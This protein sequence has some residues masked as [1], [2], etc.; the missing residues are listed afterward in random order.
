MGAAAGYR[1]L[2]SRR[3][4]QAIA[5]EPLP[6]SAAASPAPRRGEQPGGEDD[7]PDDSRRPRHRVSLSEALAA[8]QASGDAAAVDVPGPKEIAAAPEA[9][10]KALL[11]EPPAPGLPGDV[12]VVIYTTGWC[13][14]CK[15]AK[16]WM[17]DQGIPYEERDV[18]RSASYASAMRA[19]NPRGS[20]PTFDVDG[21]VM[22]GFS[23][24]SL[25]A[26]MK[27]AARRG[28]SR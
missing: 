6:A 1:V 5:P 24:Q 25:A 15:R 2:A 14:V 3:A 23:E 16:A 20:V 11:P 18:E 27:R 28:V 22:V 26:T 17:S 21:E 10:V 13:S 12:S 8:F 7:T 19:I 9:L 4:L